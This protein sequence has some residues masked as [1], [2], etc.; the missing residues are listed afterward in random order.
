MVGYVPES[1]SAVRILPTLPQAKSWARD[2][3]SELSK[4][5][6]VADGTRIFGDLFNYYLDEITS[7][8]KGARWEQVRF[9]MLLKKFTRLCAIRFTKAKP[10]SIEDR[11][12]ARLTKV[13]SSSVNR[14]ICLKLTRNVTISRFWKDGYGVLMRP[15][16][17][18][19]QMEVSVSR[20]GSAGQHDRLP[21]YC[22]AR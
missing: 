20:G 8:E 6:G 3:V 15:I 5:D 11:I 4:R 7:H 18:Q 21:T 1:T 13:K 14:G 19:R 16:Q 9:N 10:E 12:K 17:S 2:R 22:Q